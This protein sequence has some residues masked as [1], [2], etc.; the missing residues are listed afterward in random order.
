MSDKR[1]KKDVLVNDV[2]P[3]LKNKY[4]YF[5]Y[6][7]INDLLL[8]HKVG[9]TKATFKR[10]IFEA[11]KNRVIFDAGKSWY[12]GIEQKFILN[13]E[14]LNKI[15]EALNKKLPVLSF[16]CWSTEQLNSF[17]HHILSKYVSFVYVES[18]YIRSV[19]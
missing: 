2:I 8:K 10:Y 3:E 13:A 18:D 5:Y 14:P 16:Y 1:I 15:I 7:Q 6:S 9:I 11:V 12:S 19:S 4:F 17:T